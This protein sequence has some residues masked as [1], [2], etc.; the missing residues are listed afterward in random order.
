[1][2]SLQPGQCARVRWLEPA[3]IRLLFRW[4]S[5]QRQS[6]LADLSAAGAGTRHI[7][8]RKRR[9]TKELFD[10]QRTALFRT[11]CSAS[12]FGPQL[13]RAT[14]LGSQLFGTPLLSPVRAAALG[15]GPTL[16]TERRRRRG[17]AFVWWRRG[18]LLLGRRRPSPIVSTICNSFPEG[19]VQSV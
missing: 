14:V 11:E 2:E 16:R 4:R 13:L 5:E 10:A 19:P 8:R 7:Q 9:R 15:S 3:R 1:M 18:T 6:A 17:W 12:L